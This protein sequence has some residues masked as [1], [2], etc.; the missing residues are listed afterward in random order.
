MRGAIATAAL[1]IVCIT[2]AAK[3]EVGLQKLSWEFGR[4]APVTKPA[5]AKFEPI[6]SLKLENGKLGGKLRARLTLVNRGPKPT[7]GTLLRYSLAAR[8]VP[9]DG[10][11][12]GVWTIPFLIDERHVPKIGP[13]QLQDVLLD[14]SIEFG[15]FLRKAR[16]GGFAPDRLKIELMVEPRRGDAPAIQLLQNEI[17]VEK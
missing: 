8:L 13:N 15:L 14:R 7:H 11:Q 4:R 3:A 2:S 6:D 17:P 9:I 5:A 1:A 10:K 16:R 12:E